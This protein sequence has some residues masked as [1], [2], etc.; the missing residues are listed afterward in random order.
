[1]KSMRIA[2]I[3]MNA[4]L[5]E[6]RRNLNHIALWVI[7]AKRRGAAIACFP[8]MSITGYST[9]KA[10][11]AAAEPVP[12]ASSEALSAIAKKHGITILA[13]MAEKDGSGRIY[14]SHLVVTPDGL[15]GVYR[16]LHIAPAEKTVF[17]AGNEI[18][19]FKSNGITF[20]IQLCYDAHFPE[21]TTRMAA[22]GADL[23]FFPHASP[24]GTPEEKL[25]SWMRHLPA[26]AFDN[27]I[28]IA[29]CN[30]TGGNRKGLEFPGLTMVLNPSGKVIAV[31]TRGRENMLIADLKES[32]M[33][34]V[35]KHRMR[36]FL[37][38]QRSDLSGLPITFH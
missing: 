19:L 5:A 37:P 14:A 16:K 27:G 11:I 31:D 33:A 26:R 7:D 18:P 9:R 12:G 32:D 29:A 8:E 36:F 24:R 20:G 13:G 17:V 2:L 23:I 34:K 10:M 38:H 25:E 1:M 28:F 3:S 4:P 35:R 15:S 6:P 21:L 22:K 30:Q